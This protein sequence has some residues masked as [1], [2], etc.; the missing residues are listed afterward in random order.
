MFSLNYRIGRSMKQLWDLN[1]LELRT[2]G[3]EVTQIGKHRNSAKSAPCIFSNSTPPNHL[4]GNNTDSSFLTSQNFNL[5]SE[6]IGH[7]SPRPNLY[8]ECSSFINMGNFKYNLKIWLSWQHFPLKVL[9]YVKF[10]CILLQKVLW[11]P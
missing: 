10:I 7:N 4:F 3:L 6:D 8:W 1:H 11:L 5:F 2:Y 9:G